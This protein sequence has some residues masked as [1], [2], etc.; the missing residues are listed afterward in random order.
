[1][2]ATVR[3]ACHGCLASGDGSFGYPDDIVG[4]RVSAE[5]SIEHDGRVGAADPRYG[6]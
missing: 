3:A 2:F 5:V 6:R 4:H 1:M